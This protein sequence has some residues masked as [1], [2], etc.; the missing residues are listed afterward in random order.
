MEI[1]QL[2]GFIANLYLSLDFNLYYQY[3]AKSNFFDIERFFF[4]IHLFN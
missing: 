2:K 3:Q 1:F 4:T